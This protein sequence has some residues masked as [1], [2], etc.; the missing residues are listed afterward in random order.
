MRHTPTPTSPLPLLLLLVLL[1]V[2]A[3][4]CTDDAHH[5]D[6]ETDPDTRPDAG[7][8]EPHRQ[9]IE[10]ARGVEDDLAD[11][12]ARQRERIEDEGG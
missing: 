3:V 6:A 2:L 4:G 10:R 5:P 9:A 8:L 12:A 11:A 1:V 7:L